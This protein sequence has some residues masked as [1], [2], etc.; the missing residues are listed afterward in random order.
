MGGTLVAT[1]DHAWTTN[2]DATS[3]F[4]IFASGGS[5]AASVA[6]AVWDASRASYAVSG[7]F[8]EGV[9][10]LT[11]A[12][13]AANTIRDAILDY[14]FRSGRTIR[15]FFRRVDAFVTN[16]VVGLIDAAVIFYQP[17][18]TTVEFST[19]QDTD[20]GARGSSPVVTNSETP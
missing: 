12:T 11:I 17:D 6:A 15:G 19:T 8:G 3:V 2:P 1:V 7:S 4:E 14:P 20:T 5:D 18:N 10:V 13:A 16:K 9:N